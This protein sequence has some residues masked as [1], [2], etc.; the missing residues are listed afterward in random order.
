MLKEPEKESILNRLESLLH[1]VPH[2]LP[3]DMTS[4]EI[5][6]KNFVDMGIES[7][8]R[9]E[10]AFYIEKEFDINIPDERILNFNSLRDYQEYISTYSLRDKNNS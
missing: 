6:D 3:K 8:G 5:I 2:I 10:L 1:S 7:L 4:E 9:Y